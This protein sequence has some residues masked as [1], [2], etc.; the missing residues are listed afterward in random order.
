MLLLIRCVM[1]SPQQAPSIFPNKSLLGIFQT[2]NFCSL[3]IPTKVLADNNL[4][5]NP[6]NLNKQIIVQ[7]S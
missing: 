7:K 1:F 2:S 3:L 5:C 6:F 4:S